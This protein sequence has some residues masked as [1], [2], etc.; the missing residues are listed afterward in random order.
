MPHMSHRVAVMT[1]V[2]ALSLEAAGVFFLLRQA[3]IRHSA[4]WFV[5]LSTLTVSVSAWMLAQLD[6]TP[7]VS[8]LILLG[9]SAVL[10]VLA[11]VHPPLT[12]DDDFRYV[13]DAKV[14]LAGTDPYAYEPQAPQLVPL[15]D[16]FL[17]PGGDCPHPIPGSCT[18]INRPNVHTVYPPVAEGAFVLIRVAS[19]GGHGNHVPVQIAAMLGVL[20]IGALLIKHALSRE[21]SLWPVALWTWGPLPVV[22]FSN[23]GHIDWLAIL[24]VLGALMIAGQRRAGL[25]GVLIGAAILTKLY[26]ALVL[27]ALL[28]HRAGRVIAVVGAMTLATYLPHVFAVGGKVIGYL[29]GYL[30][31]EG[32]ANGDRLMLIGAVF[33]HPVDTLVGALVLAAVLWFVWR[34]GDSLAAEQ[35]AVILMGAALL[36]TTP[37][38]GW[39]AGLLLALVV[40]AR[41]YEWLPVAIVP[42]IAY[43]IRGGISTWIGT[44]RMVYVAAVVFS[45]AIHVVRRRAGSLAQGFSA[46][47]TSDAEPA[48][49]APQAVAS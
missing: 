20:A 45:L 48:D 7:R 16:E 31:E 21:R 23:A 2:L 18:N 37:A 40:M 44:S 10:Q 42:T 12:S 17:F 28:R 25:T 41:A 35:A 14:Q 34:R 6:L 4:L 3:S 15:R 5:C 32:Y 33:P 9:A 49:A 46:L 19:A 30:H 22:E 26:P 47:A 27:P 13:W 1:L 24:F 8:A 36:V 39:Y 11:V 38:Y 29:P 43:L